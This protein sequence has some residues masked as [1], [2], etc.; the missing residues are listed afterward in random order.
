MRLHYHIKSTFKTL[1]QLC[2]EQQILVMLFFKDVS[3]VSIIKTCIFPSLSQF[4]LFLA[5][6]LFLVLNFLQPVELLSLKLIKLRDD[7]GQS[8]LNARDDD[9]LDSIDTSVGGL[10]DLIQGDERCLQRSKLHQQ[11]DSFL[12]ISLQP[13]ELLPPHV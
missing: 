13:L 3:T 1:F 4:F 11:V 10:D 9:M 6:F 8:A 12:I 7:V 5:N 2:S